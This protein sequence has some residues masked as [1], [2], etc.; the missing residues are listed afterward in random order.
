MQLSLDLEV[1]PPSPSPQ[2]TQA[3]HVRHIVLAALSRRTQWS[4][5]SFRLAVDSAINEAGITRRGLAKALGL[6][7]SMVARAVDVTDQR[8][9]CV[10][11]VAK[12]LGYDASDDQASA[13]FRR[14]TDTIVVPPV[15]HTQINPDTMRAKEIVVDVLGKE[16]PMTPRRFAQVLDNALTVNRLT[17]RHL[18]VQCDIAAT[19]VW[20]ALI[21]NEPAALVTLAGHLGYAVD[22]G[23]MFRRATR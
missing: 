6:S 14:R 3:D 10:R 4:L 23:G 21:H 18:A 7:L 15:P 13:V 20:A 8:I 9:S 5:R 16:P 12:A 1:A 11:A 2:M 19:T 17:R 22:G